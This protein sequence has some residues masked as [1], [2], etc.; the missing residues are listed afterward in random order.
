[1]PTQSCQLN[2]KQG[3]KAVPTGKCYTYTTDRGRSLAIMRAKTQ[4]R[5]IARNKK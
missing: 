1:M 2:G 3:F 4:L 5:A